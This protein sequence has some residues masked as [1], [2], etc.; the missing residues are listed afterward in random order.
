[1]RIAMVTSDGLEGLALGVSAAAA[2]L[3]GQGNPSR[4]GTAPRVTVR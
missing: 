1:M 2:D 4:C 3:G